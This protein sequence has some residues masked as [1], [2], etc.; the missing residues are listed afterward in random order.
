MS[1]FS[2]ILLSVIVESIF[3][4]VLSK[5][6]GRKFVKGLL[7]LFGFFIGIRIDLPVLSS[8]VWLSIISFNLFA[9]SWCNS[10]GLYSGHRRVYLTI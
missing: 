8:F 7:S 2:R 6:I 1:T 9:I 4:I 5:F 3:L 10:P